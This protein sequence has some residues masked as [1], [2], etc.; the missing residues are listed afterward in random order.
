MKSY[1]DVASSNTMSGQRPHSYRTQQTGTG[2]E[3]SDDDKQHD[4]SNGQAGNAQIISC[5]VLQPLAEIFAFDAEYDCQ[6][7][8]DDPEWSECKSNDRTSQRNDAC[9]QRLFGL[10]LAAHI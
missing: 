10:I 8:G 7:D 9:G 4:H 3:R 5:L 2:S 1:V 6:H